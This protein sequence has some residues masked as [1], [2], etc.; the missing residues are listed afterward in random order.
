MLRRLRPTR[1]IIL[2][3]LAFAFELHVSARSLSRRSTLSYPA[4]AIMV[5]A[6]TAAGMLAL[7]LGGLSNH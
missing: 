2:T 5:W 7:L 3:S 4:A 1:R 6:T